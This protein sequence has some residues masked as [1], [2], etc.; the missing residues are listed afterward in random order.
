MDVI[1]CFRCGNF[2]YG[3]PTDWA[4][5]NACFRGSPRTGDLVRLA[6]EAFPDDE[7]I[8]ALKE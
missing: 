8:Q 2:Y 1:I 4:K 3:P 7:K 6:K 5:E